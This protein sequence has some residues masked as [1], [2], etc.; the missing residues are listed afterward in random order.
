MMLIGN[1][2]P[3]GADCGNTWYPATLSLFFSAWRGSGD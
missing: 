3:P 2:K 1:V